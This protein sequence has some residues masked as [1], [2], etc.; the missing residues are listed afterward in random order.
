M[1]SFQTHPRPHYYRNLVEVIQELD[2]PTKAVPYNASYQS[3]KE[4]LLVTSTGWIGHILQHL[5]YVLW[6]GW[7]AGD[8]GGGRL[9]MSFFFERLSDCT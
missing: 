1:S 7:Q 8:F 2:V 3:G 5:K 6:M 9:F 4:M